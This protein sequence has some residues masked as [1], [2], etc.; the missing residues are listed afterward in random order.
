MHIFDSN[1]KGVGAGGRNYI[2]AYIRGQ[3]SNG[4]LQTMDCKMPPV[5]RIFINRISNSTEPLPD[6]TKQISIIKT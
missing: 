2:L 1:A 6:N 3:K 5:R 4:S